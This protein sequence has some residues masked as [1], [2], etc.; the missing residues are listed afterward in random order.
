LRD[1]KSWLPAC[2]EQTLQACRDAYAAPFEVR[3]LQLKVST[4]Y[5]SVTNSARISLRA[6]KVS[7]V[8]KH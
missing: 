1:A 6:S 7:L 2:T 4:E 8:Y 5:N 3:F